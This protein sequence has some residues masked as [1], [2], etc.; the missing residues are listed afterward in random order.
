MPRLRGNAINPHPRSRLRSRRNPVIE[1]RAVEPDIEA[2]R[3][4]AG[5][6]FADAYR[7]A[8]GNGDIDARSIA[9]RAFAEE[10]RWRTGLTALRNILVSPFGLKTSGSHEAGALG[11]LG[12]FPVLEEARDRLVAGFDDAHLDFRVVVAI[13]RAAAG[14]HVTLTTV[15][16]THNALGRAYL[17]VILPFHRR[18]A[19]SML[20]QM[21]AGGSP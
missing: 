10:P 12:L 9:A 20:R 6:Q 3:L 4:L 15:V 5:A 18:I 13:S 7:A 14:S 11:M 19:R 2:I 1:V 16:R 8:F 21:A 17:A